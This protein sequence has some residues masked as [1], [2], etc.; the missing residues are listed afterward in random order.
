MYAKEHSYLKSTSK[1]VPKILYSEQ[2]LRKL[3]LGLYLKKSVKSDNILNC[4]HGL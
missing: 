3:M 2:M 1:N 4:V